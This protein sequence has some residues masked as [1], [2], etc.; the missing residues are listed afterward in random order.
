MRGQEPL[1][2]HWHARLARAGLD[3]DGHGILD[4]TRNV[5]EGQVKWTLPRF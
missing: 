5:E 4:V 2:N 3:S 1:D